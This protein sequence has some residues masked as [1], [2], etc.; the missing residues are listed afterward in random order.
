MKIQVKVKAGAR[1]NRV[2]FDKEQNLYI[3][4]TKVQPIEGKAN[5]SVVKLIAGHF[6]VPKSSVTLKTGQ[7]SKIKIF[8][9]D[10]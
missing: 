1:E 10:R 6:K 7:Q 2:S 9:I 8:E 5:E 4:T 3:V